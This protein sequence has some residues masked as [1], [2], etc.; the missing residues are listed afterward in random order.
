M[1]KKTEQTVGNLKRYL[2]NKSDEFQFFHP[3]SIAR[4]LGWV[5]AGDKIDYLPVPL[6]VTHSGGLSDR[7]LLRGTGSGNTLLPIIIFHSLPI[8]LHYVC[9]CLVH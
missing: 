2:F 1:L 3:R 4:L 6:V 8:Y 5:N 7:R 9:K